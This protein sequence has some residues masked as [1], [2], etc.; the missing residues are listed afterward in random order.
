M[1]DL[2]LSEVAA[3]EHVSLLG[4]FP[5]QSHSPIRFGA[6]VCRNAS[7]HSAAF[8]QYLETPEA[9]AVFQRYGFELPGTTV[10]G[11]D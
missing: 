6:A 9:A 8:L 1:R 2:Y 5:P 4:V 3:S 7:P 10:S 11:D